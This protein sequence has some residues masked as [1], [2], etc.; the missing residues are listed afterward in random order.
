MWKYP[1]R[2]VKKGQGFFVPA[3]DVD[4]ALEAGLR[5]AVSVRVLDASGMPCIRQGLLG[6]LFYRK[7]PARKSRT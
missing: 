5:A 6:V 4:K 2:Q 7:P 3:L 1:W